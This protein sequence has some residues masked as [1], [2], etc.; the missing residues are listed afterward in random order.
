MCKRK[1]RS[2][3]RSANRGFK[4]SAAY[5][6]SLKELAQYLCVVSFS[7]LL[8]R[9]TIDKAEKGHFYSKTRTD[10]QQQGNVTFK[11]HFEG[12]ASRKP[13]P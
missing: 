10:G 9:L 8:G 7:R 4:V 3:N 6:C 1:H 5:R 13:L 12:G 11:D 2:A